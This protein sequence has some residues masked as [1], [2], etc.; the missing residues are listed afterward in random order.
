MV[1]DN[2]LKFDPKHE[3]LGASPSKKVTAPPKAK[4]NPYDATQSPPDIFTFLPS[5]GSKF[6]LFSDPYAT[7]YYY[8]PNQ[9]RNQGNYWLHKRE[10]ERAFTEKEIA[11]IDFLSVYRLAT[12]K[13]IARAVFPEEENPVK[14]RD[15][16]KR[17]RKMGFI[18][19]FSWVTPLKE[20]RK[21]PLVY[22]L[23]RIGCEAAEKLFHRKTPKDFQFQPVVFKTGRGPNMEPFFRDL[24]A[25]ELLAE[26]TRLDRVV[27]WERK[28]L[29]R[30]TDG[31]YH[32]PYG[33][34]ELIKDAGEFLTFWIEVIRLS[35]DWQDQA[36]TRFKY[37]QAAIEK[38]DPFQKPKRLIL[39]VDSDARIPYV[40]RL[41]EEYMPSA[42]VRWTTDERLLMGLGEETFLLYDS[43][44]KTI[45]K[46]PM[47]FLMDGHNGMGA[48]EYLA[49]QHLNF[50]VEEDEFEDE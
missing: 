37:T 13:Q 39:I 8:E 38:L 44:T 26:L 15:F 29:I 5:D 22:G 7:L 3:D 47:S 24:V 17:S 34:V 45:K 25:N 40:A 33:T 4:N 20:E 30:L 41:A 10:E 6:G 14:I 46:S 18:T 21:K 50:D 49:Q 9:G 43:N 36:I 27:S 28:K 12:Q 32:H 1:A 35:Y 19:S 16:I 2:L 31:M 48:R 23:T 42:E 11:L